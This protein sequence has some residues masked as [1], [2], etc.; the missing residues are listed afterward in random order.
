MTIKKAQINLSLGEGLRP[1][2]K[3]QLGKNIMAGVTLAAIAIPEVIGYTKI[4]QTPIITGIYTMLVPVIIFA[5]LGS[6]KHLVI[7]ADSATAAI[8]AQGLLPLAAAGSS[9]YMAYVTLLTLVTA[10]LLLICSILR[11]GFI[12]KFLSRTV[13]IGFLTGVGIQVAL[14]QI[15]GM[16]GL[17]GGTGNALEKII[18]PFTILEN[19]NLYA[20]AFSA[21][22][23][24][25]V[26]IPKG[27]FKKHKVIDKIP[28]AFIA[29]TLTILLNYFLNLTH[30]LDTIG[31][32]PGGLPQVVLPTFSW[33]ALVRVFPISLSIV[34][35]I[36]TQS[37]ATA[38]AY[39][40]RYG[41][42][43]Y[44]NKDLFGLSLAN[45]SAAFTGTFVVNGSPTKTQI[46]D[47]AGGRTQLANL[48]CAGLVLM[49]LLFLTG[50]ISYLPTA[51]LS[52][53]VFTIGIHLIDV[54]NLI[55]LFKEKRNE[56][57]IALL[58]AVVVVI[59]GVSYGIVFAVFLA[60]IE[61]VYRGTKLRNF[62]IVPTDSEKNGN[63]WKWQP[64]TT[65]QEACPG[66]VIY[67]FA[68]S[69]FYGNA[70][71]FTKDIIS[72][73]KEVANLKVMVL[74][75]TSIPDVDF[76]G[77][78][79][80]LEMHRRLTEK[81]IRVYYVYVDEHVKKQLK[82]YGVMNSLDDV[83]Y[84]EGYEDIYRLK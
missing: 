59:A 70:D 83:G 14:G 16:L 13:L 23:L 69:F 18:Y 49:V 62:L 51:A 27:I 54:K 45:L 39:A 15:S 34:L 56:F 82:N 7:G 24:V 53:L 30:L 41:E 63:V 75:F 11:L 55:S 77:G 60:M 43:D 73:T 44:V 58:T 20:L 28:W 76:T 80:L 22:V 68:A 19:T 72:L 40:N 81:N 2:H 36:I 8:M 61:H 64:I 57:F 84:L 33:A 4:S 67:H 21:M 3:N 5:L 79:V 1:F 47:E 74:D 9:S 25:F 38:V 35:V 66:L 26:F 6:S 46:V 78:Q 10:A 52:A 29:I 71:N 32:V 37:S 42:E 48:T 50:P 12:A 31:H 65:Y 17:S